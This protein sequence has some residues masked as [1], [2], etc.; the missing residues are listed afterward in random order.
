MGAVGTGA[1]D[2]SPRFDVFVDDYSLYDSPARVRFNIRVAS[3]KFYSDITYHSI[4]RWEDLWSRYGSALK[5]RLL[6]ALAAWEGMRFL[7]LG[8]Q[9]LVI[10]DGLQCDGTVQQWWT[11]CFR[12][13]LGEW[14]YRNQASYPDET[15]PRLIAEESTGAQINHGA[16]FAEE[17]WLLTNGGG[18]DT[19]AS[20]ILFEKANAT[21]DL[22]EGYLP[23]GGSLQR[24]Q[25]LLLQLRNAVAPDSATTV[26][27]TI[28]DNFFSCNDEDI[29]AV[30]VRSDHYKTDFAVGHTA[31]YIG[32]FPIILYHKY[33]RVWFNIEKSADDAMV[34]WNGESINHQWCKSLEYHEIS[35]QVFK[36]LTGLRWF[37]GFGSPLRGL[38]DTAIYKIVSSRS[39]LLNKTHSCNY[40]KPWCGYC[41]KCLFCYLMM[42]AYI[43]EGFAKGVVGSQE[44]LFARE[45]FY[46]RWEELLSPKK[47]AWE[48]VPSH[49]E[50]QLAAF[51]CLTRGIDYPVLRRFAAEPRESGRLWNRFAAIDW[52]RVPAQIAT[53]LRE[54]VKESHNPL[55][56]DAI[57]VGAGQAGLSASYHLTESNISHVVLERGEVGDA[58]HRRWD[59]FQINTPNKFTRFP[60]ME[61]AGDDPDGF[62]DRRTIAGWLADYAQRFNL[63]VTTDCRVICVERMGNNFKVASD[64]GTWL[65]K[66]LVVASGHY[67]EAYCP[68]Q[69]SAFPKSVSVLHSCDY[70]NPDALPTG[71]VLVIG[72]G[73]SGVQI[74]EDL[75][76]AG[77]TVYWCISDRPCNFRRYRGEDFMHWWEVGGLQHR[78]IYDHPL[79]MEGALDAKRWLR[80]M[81]FPLVSGKGADGRGHSISYKKLWEQGIILLGRFAGVAGTKVTIKGDVRESVASANR[82]TNEIRRELDGIAGRFGARAETFIEGLDTEWLP[83][84]VVA[85]LDLGKENINAVIFATGYKPAWPWLHVDGLCDEMGYPMGHIGMHPVP[86]LYFIGLFN[87]QRLSS[88]CLCNGGRDAAVIVRDLQKY[89]LERAAV[90]ELVEAQ[91]TTHS[92]NVTHVLVVLPTSRDRVALAELQNETIHFHYLEEAH[93][94][95]FCICPDFD[96][97]AYT[98]RCILYAREV[99]ARVVLYGHDTASLI[100]A[101]VAEDLQLPGPPF[102]AAFLTCHKVYSRKTESRPINHRV[103]DLESP[104]P[105]GDNYQ[106]PG[107][108]KPALL[109]GSAVQ[110]NILSTSDLEVGIQQL[111]S[112]A[113]P[114]SAPYRALFQRHVDTIRYPLVERDVALLEDL[115]IGAD[116]YAVEGWSDSRSVPHLWAISDNHYFRTSPPHLDKNVLPTKL[117]GGLQERLTA[118]AFETAISHKMRSGFWNVEI[119]VLPNGSLQVTEINGRAISSLYP[120]YKAVY[121]RSLY[122]A[123]L[124]LARGH[125][126]GVLEKRPKDAMALGAMVAISTYGDGCLR[127]LLDLS[128]LERVR[129]WDGVL[130]VV[131]MH[132]ED[133]RTS[134]TQTG[135]VNLLARA[136]VVG[137]TENELEDLCRR[138]RLALLRGTASGEEHKSS[139]LLQVAK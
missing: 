2:A 111:K 25:E 117:D 77:R 51:V 60:E 38:H 99:R 88:I 23:V 125:D 57:V 76:E 3:L 11:H 33:T 37:E 30:G 108:L 22:Y 128:A 124:D 84:N 114:W 121:A 98:R 113:T 106:L 12:G 118:L 42:T 15:Y 29:R 39:N 45:D 65:T 20:L 6:G 110:R 94:A 83:P 64:E 24:Q 86:G 135:G 129:Q 26:K 35:H 136:Y 131:L 112:S 66:S 139:R 73:Q 5:P 85:E 92:G 97:V 71:N 14:R 126:Q 53:A 10:C 115:I 41:P 103:I 50:C 36:H 7:A 122:N 96:A 47:V 43:D 8:G 18:K 34:D 49:E 102:E 4:P 56:L 61:Y 100:A 120:I 32:Y 19:L 9:R 104:D 59:S 46:W 107:H 63:P 93:F 28:Q 130:Q 81:E 54:V 70:R 74:A 119:W 16:D 62:A 89:L 105:I 127:D 17:K 69:A 52:S 82:A 72:G 137:K 78:S 1:V 116:Q 31:N 101:A 91:S 75:H 44:S 80:E 95:P 123:L 133:Y 134:W 27:V 58:W 109:T 68:S 55:F 67:G 21:Y 132:P 48:C 138:L 87:L 90:T 13:Q 79:M 40:G